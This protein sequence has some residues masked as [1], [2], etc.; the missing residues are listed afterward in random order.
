V[1]EK[2]RLK[3]QF[4]SLFL[5]QL[6]YGRLEGPLQAFKE[7]KLEAQMSYD[8]NPTFTEGFT[9]TGTL[10]FSRTNMRILHGEFGPRINIGHHAIQPSSP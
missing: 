1:R 6:P 8:F 5:Q 3:L 10:T 9:D 4:A 2:T 7:I